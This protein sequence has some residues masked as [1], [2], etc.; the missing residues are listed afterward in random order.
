MVLNKHIRNDWNNWGV[1][2]GRPKARVTTLCGKLTSV[3]YAGVP[4]VD[5]GQS[6]GVY[7]DGDYGWCISCC[8][9]FI[10]EAL[11]VLDQVRKSESKALAGLYEDAIKIVTAQV[12]LARDATSVK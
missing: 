11:E 12:T 4:G 2:L 8:T 10:L 7:G 5:P 9:V 1:Y 6:A 3:K